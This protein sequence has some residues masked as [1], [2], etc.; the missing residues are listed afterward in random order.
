MINRI[1]MITLSILPIL[2]KCRRLIEG[3]DEPLLLSD[4]SIFRDSRI[5]VF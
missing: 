2:S 4:E 1:D 5:D 3:S